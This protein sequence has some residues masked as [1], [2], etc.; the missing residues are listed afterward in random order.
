MDG[1]NVNIKFHK[2]IQEN[3]VQEHNNCLIDIGSCSLHT[4]YNA[5]KACFQKMK[6]DLDEF[7]KGLYNLFEYSPARRDDYVKTGKVNLFPLHFTNIR[8]VDNGSVAQR[9]RQILPAITKYIQ[10]VSATNSEPTCKSYATVKNLILDPLLESKLCFFEWLANELEPFLRGYQ[11]NDPKAAFLF[12]D[13]SNLLINILER[14]VKKDVLEKY[15]RNIL[16]IN[17]KDEK[18]FMA[19]DYIKLDIGTKVV[20]KSVTNT[21]D[22][23]LFKTQCQNILKNFVSKLIE[24]SCLKY[25]FIKGISCLNPD[26]TLQQKEAEK[27]ISIALE[28]LAEK[29]IMSTTNCNKVE[30]EFKQIISFTATKEKLGSF[31]RED[32]RLDHFWISTLDMYGCDK[33]QNLL[34]FIKKIM[35]LS[36]GNAFLERGFSINQ[37]CVVEN[38]KEKTL[39]AQRVICDAIDAMNKPLDQFNV[40]KELIKCVRMSNSLYKEELAKE[41]AKREKEQDFQKNKRRV[42]AEIKELTNK[43]EKILESAQKQAAKLEEEISSYRKILN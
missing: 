33:Y 27:R 19:V 37:D 25:P 2:D 41:K 10:N 16:K 23:I 29:N 43:K 26:I 30:S 8:W 31:K 21:S 11:S 18:N 38:Q 17:L 34:N 20:L 35:I 9:A 40:N 13:L 42:T 24:K 36:H 5:F 32:T 4:V 22:K 39:I 7:L 28:Y 1:P 14:I 6:W 15:S 3:I 12:S